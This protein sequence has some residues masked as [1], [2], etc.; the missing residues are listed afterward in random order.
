LCPPPTPQFADRSAADTS[1][2]RGAP[3][4]CPI[5]T[6]CWRRHRLRHPL[7]RRPRRVRRPRPRHLL[8]RRHRRRCTYRPRRT[9]TYARTSG[10]GSLSAVA[11]ESTGNVERP[12]GV[13]GCMYLITGAAGEVSRRVVELLA[14][15]GDPV[16][17][18]R[19]ISPAPVAL[20]GRARS[21]LVGSA[22]RPRAPD[23]RIGEVYEL[24]GP[25][26]LDVSE[27]AEQFS[28][29]PGYRCGPAVL[30]GSA[31]A[32]RRRPQ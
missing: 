30:A 17:R 29:A 6:T 13:I 8:R 25:Q 9:S 16:R 12:W 3:T 15:R 26:V 2:S 18:H 11:S 5:S 1:T 21:R 23:G 22:G 28:R 20:A 4:R 7:R 14:S 24:T 27:L 31:G 10:G 19:R 32:D